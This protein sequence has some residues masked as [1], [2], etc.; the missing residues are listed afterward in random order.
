[1]VREVFRHFGRYL[2]E[3]L[4]M[5]RTADLEASLEGDAH[6]REA[7]RRYRCAIVLTGHLGNWEVGA[8]LLQRMGFPV[9]VVAL[10]HDD[11]ATD[12]FFNAQRRRC[13]VE[14]IPLG[15]SA[16]QQSLRR[17]R[18]GQVLGVLGDRVFAGDGL[19]CAVD[20]LRM[21]LPL[22]PATL[23]V[24][25]QAPIIPAFVVRQRPGAFRFLF[26]PPLQPMTG[27]EP[28]IQAYAAVL[29]KYLRR[30]PEQWLMFQPLQ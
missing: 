19:S 12:R 5:H 18:Q 29:A 13:G 28:M 15:A 21:T 8:A 14:V 23:S 10:P 11:A 17:L 4:T 2:V 9:S 20:G 16:A 7:Y 22:G 24:R 6:L 25:A 1:M 26:E 3:F 30:F 27:V